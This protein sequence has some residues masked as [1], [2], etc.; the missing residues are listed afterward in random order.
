MRKVTLKQ[1][2]NKAMKDRTF[3]TSLRKDAAKTLYENGLQLAAADQRRLES[4]LA[5]DGKT[6]RVD[7]DKV[8]KARA[9]VKAD[10]FGGLSWIMMW[11]HIPGG[12]IGPRPETRRPAT[13]RAGTRR[14]G[15][16]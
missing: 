5:L 7:L 11:P 6:V 14:P 2:A 13:R 1:V 15:T 8:M 9:R 3:F 16:P 12:P 4:I 10:R